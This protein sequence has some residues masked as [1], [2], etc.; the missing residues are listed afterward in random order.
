[1]L[2]D[3]PTA[4]AFVDPDRRNDR[5]SRLA[6][7]DRDGAN[8]GFLYRGQQLA[9]V[10]KWRRHDQA[11]GAVALEDRRQQPR[12]ILALGIDRSRD[13]VA[14]QRRASA[15]GA[16]L[17]A[18]MIIAVGLALGVVGMDQHDLAP[19]A[20]G[21][22]ARLL[23]DR[24]AELLDRAAHALA[25]FGAHVLAI[26]ENARHGHPRHPGRFGDIV[27]GEA[28]PG[29]AREF[30][31]AC[32]RRQR[33]SAGC[34]ASRRLS[35]IRWRQPGGVGGMEQDESSLFKPVVGRCCVALEP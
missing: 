31:D 26:V 18:G 12:A 19:G 13:Q 27:D 29:H 35:L 34:C 9:V 21:Q 15:Q 6:R 4:R 5:P 3:H 11:R 32:G 7:R 1:M 8:A 24:I 28:L 25:G 33:P 14:P 23:V 17:E 20:A 16:E 22:R 10:G 2:A 30:G